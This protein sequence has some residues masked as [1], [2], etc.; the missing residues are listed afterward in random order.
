MEREYPTTVPDPLGLAAL[1]TEREALLGFARECEW[2]GR[3]PFDW[4][5]DWQL[6][7]V[8]LDESYAP[9]PTG[10]SAHLP[11]DY[12]HANSVG[13]AAD[14]NLI[15]SAR[16][17]WCCYKIDRRTGE[18]IWRLG[19]KKSDF[20]SMYAK[21]EKT[22]EKKLNELIDVFTSIDS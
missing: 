6:E 8:G 20:A 15:V 19:G 16:H 12:F 4:A 9:L 10:E 3:C 11:Y 14:G 18:V 21:K 1:E 17:T 5:D 2:S 22:Y 7:H 13:L